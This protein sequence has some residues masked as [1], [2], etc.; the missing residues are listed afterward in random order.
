MP[1]RLIRRFRYQGRFPHKGGRSSGLELRLSV[2]GNPEPANPWPMESGISQVPAAWTFISAALDDGRWWAPQRL[3]QAISAARQEQTD[4]LRF[5]T[6][7]VVIRVTR[8]AYYRISPAT[9]ANEPSRT[10]F[11]LTN[12]TQDKGVWCRYGGW[13]WGGVEI[14]AGRRKTSAFR[15]RVSCARCSRWGSEGLVAPISPHSSPP[16]ILSVR[17]TRTCDLERRCSRHL[18]HQLLNVDSVTLLKAAS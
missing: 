14:E 6:S 12:Q 2:P 17:G 13:G 10:Q 7:N 8:D 18:M 5:R 4:G 3:P 16:G 1:G 9:L 15:Q 11:N